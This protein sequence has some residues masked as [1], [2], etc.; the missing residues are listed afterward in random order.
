MKKYPIPK[1]TIEII[2][3]WGFCGGGG[4]G[5]EIIMIGFVREE[6]FKFKFKGFKKGLKE[7]VAGVA[8]VAAL[9]GENKK[10]AVLALLVVVMFLFIINMEYPLL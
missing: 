2:N 7:S 3:I 4:G 8:G 9:K 1:L 5:G 6:V 10:G